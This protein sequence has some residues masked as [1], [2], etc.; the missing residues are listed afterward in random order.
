[1]CRCGFEALSTHN[2][3]APSRGVTAEMAC[4]EMTLPQSSGANTPRLDKTIV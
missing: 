4:T 3:G 2:E 1:M